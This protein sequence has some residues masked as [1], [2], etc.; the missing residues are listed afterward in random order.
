MTRWTTVHGFLAMACVWALALCSPVRAADEK[1]LIIEAAPT[2]EIS[3]L[4]GGDFT[5]RAPGSARG[6]WSVGTLVAGDDAAKTPCLEILKTADKAVGVSYAQTIPLEMGHTY[7]FVV[8]YRTDMDGVQLEM[9]QYGFHTWGDTVRPI[10]VALP[11]SPGEYQRVEV[12]LDP[13]PGALCVGTWISIPQKAAGALRLREYALNGPAWGG[14]SYP[15]LTPQ[16]QKR[17]NFWQLVEFVRNSVPINSQYFGPGAQNSSAR[18]RGGGLGD[19]WI[20]L[21]A[22][23]PA[24]QGNYRLGLEVRENDGGKLLARYAGTFNQPADVLPAARIRVPGI[25]RPCQ[26]EVIGWRE[27]GTLVGKRTVFVRFQTHEPFTTPAVWDKLPAQQDAWPGGGQLAVRVTGGMV[28]DFH[29]GQQLTGAFDVARGKEARIV[30]LAVTRYDRLSV[31]KQDV[32]VEAGQGMATFPFSFVAPNAD[33][34]EINVKLQAGDRVLDERELRLG[35]RDAH[36][37]RPFVKPDFPAMELVEEQR[38]LSQRAAP[39]A[40]SQFAAFLTDIKTHGSTIAGIGY[41]LNEFNPMP[42]VYRFDEL[43]RRVKLAAAAGLRSQ[44]Y[45]QPEAWPDWAGWEA[46]VDQNGTPDICLSV[47]SPGVRRIVADAY[48]ALSVHFRGDSSVVAY[49]LWDTWADWIYRDGEGK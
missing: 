37:E 15:T 5:A 39:A 27:D 41:G 40:E 25:T 42:G 28:Q 46:P 38:F 19:P 49:G 22:I 11:K 34:Y 44:I 29:A 21:G 6:N 8:Q 3:W 17:P 36:P 26:L 20:P 43:E 47:A 2:A 14:M 1:P 24:K 4:E 18:Q 10:R 48:R 9:H 16:E 33:V 32:T 12:K 45:L 13:A 31:A 23:I 35:L 30:H 7:R